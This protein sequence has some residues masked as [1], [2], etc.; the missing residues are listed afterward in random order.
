MPW[1]LIFF[2]VVITIITIR[3]GP[4]GCNGDCNQGRNQCNCRSETKLDQKKDTTQQ[5]HQYMQNNYYLRYYNLLQ[6]IKGLFK[7]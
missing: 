7:K 3:I 4:P 6:F 1:I 2:V 5:L